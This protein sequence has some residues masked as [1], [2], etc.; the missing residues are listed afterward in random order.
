MRSIVRN[1]LLAACSLAVAA[2]AASA[3]TIQGNV[4]CRGVRDCTGALVF[5]ESLPG[6][7]FPP[8]SDAVMDQ[9]NLTFVP[10]VLAVVV[11][12]RV[13]FPN[14]DE[15]RHNVFSPSPVK[16]FNLGTYP[17]GVAKYVVFDKP[18]VV[19]LLCNVHAEMGAYV[20]V[21]ETPYSAL[22]AKDGAYVLKG[23]P[24]GTYVVR[25]WREELKDQRQEVTVS[26]GTS[27]MVNFELRR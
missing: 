16:R 8:T 2:S 21:T 7:S 14:S 18:G 1:T 23:V 10:H 13:T 15:V 27:Q 20:V 19:E 12:T 26:G 25:A 5:I 4:I 17:K 6:R 22:V 3:D 11:G 24:T 9:L